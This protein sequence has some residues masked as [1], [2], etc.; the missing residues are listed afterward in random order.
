MNIKN[1]FNVASEKKIYQTP[2]IE[3]VRICVEQGF[4]GSDGNL[5]TPGQD[6]EEEM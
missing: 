2:E 3:I 6:D 5:E 1:L 4:A